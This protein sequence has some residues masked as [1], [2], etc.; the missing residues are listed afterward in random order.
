MRIV[1][2]AFTL[3]VGA[4][5]KGDTGARPVITGCLTSPR[6]VVV[7][8]ICSVGDADLPNSKYNG[9]TKRSSWEDKMTGTQI[10]HVF[11]SQS[12][13]SISRMAPTIQS[14]QVLERSRLQLFDHDGYLDS[15][16]ACLK[17][18]LWLAASRSKI[19]N[20]ISWHAFSECKR[21]KI[22][23]PRKTCTY[24]SEEER[25]AA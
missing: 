20:A 4:G 15:V 22:L 5:S 10:S 11:Q 16:H 14:I 8:V 2:R 13:N 12:Q 24:L 21:V 1:G 23:R 18:G 3:V 6:C 25:N 7:A 9:S 17:I 19:D